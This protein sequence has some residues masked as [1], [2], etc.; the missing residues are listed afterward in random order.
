[1]NKF[2][3]AGQDTWVEEMTRGKRDGYFVDVGAYDGI[4]SSNTLYLENALGWRGSCIEAG[5]EQ[6]QALAA[7]R[8]LSTNV[9]M[10][11]MPYTG[12]CGFTGC[13][14]DEV[15]ERVPCA[16]LTEILQLVQAPHLIDYMSIDIEGGEVGAISTMDWTR[17]KVNLI[18]IE[19]NLYINGPQQKNQIYGILSANGFVR[20]VDNA[21]CLDPNPAWHMQPYEDWYAHKDFLFAKD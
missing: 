18:T 13:S 2:S 12:L 6:F 8:P 5:R 7:N 10:A 11:V 20:V 3:Q 16:P 21:P 14:V 17:Y 9:N 4:E 19:H 1:M 15:G